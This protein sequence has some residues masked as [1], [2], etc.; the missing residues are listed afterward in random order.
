MSFS[1]RLHH[2]AVRGCLAASLGVAG[3][4]WSAVAQN[5]S[6]PKDNAP[7]QKAQPEQT[8]PRAVVIPGRDGQSP[9][10]VF[11]VP[12]IVPEQK[13]AEPGTYESSCSS[14]K[15][16]D[17]ADLCEQRRMA[18]AAEEAVTVATNQYWVALAALLGLVLTLAANAYAAV[19]AAH[20]ADAAVESAKIARN[21]QRP[22]FRPQNAELKNWQKA[23]QEHNELQML[24]VWMSI[25][26][27]GSGVG[28]LESYGM[29]NEV[30][31]HGQ[32]FGGKELTVRCDI[33]RMSIMSDSI[34]KL[35]A[36]L[37]AFQ[38]GPDHTRLELIEFKKTLY[39]YGYFRYFDLFGTYWRTGFMFEFRAMR[40]SG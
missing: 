11:V 39:V 31:P 32:S 3:F 20:S 13:K 5:V 12:I 1:S 38:L 28:F 22:Y 7:Q 19:A 14:P 40:E 37:D 2:V 29:A 4:N 17:E 34:L 36:A 23:I 24:E 35:G 18:K 15:N 10:F 25:E 21:G 30:V 33:G 8:A 26:N 6:Q 9:T 16:H 27:V